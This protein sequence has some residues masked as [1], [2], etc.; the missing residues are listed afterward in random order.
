M[1]IV[2]KI[3]LCYGVLLLIALASVGFSRWSVSQAMYQLERAR[4]ANESYDHHLMLLAH[5]YR[6]FKQFG[7]TLLI[8]NLGNDNLRE[9]KALELAIKH[10]IKTIKMAIAKEI[11]MVGS[12]EIKAL[13]SIGSI[14][15]LI[16]S[17]VA[18]YRS[19]RDVHDRA[20]P[21]PSLDLLAKILERR[22][23][24]EF[25]EKINKTLALEATEM[26]AMQENT[27]SVFDFLNTVQTIFTGVLLVAAAF[28]I[29]LFVQDITKP[30]RRLI[31][32][33]TEFS[34]G[35]WAHRISLA[36]PH[37]MSKIAAILNASAKTAQYREGELEK[38]K[39][40][41]QSEIDSSAVELKATLE[42]LEIEVA[43]RKKLLADVSHELRTPLTIIQGEASVA[44]RREDTTLDEYREAL[45]RTKEAAEH[46]SIL[47]NDLLF[48]AR[49]ETGEV[50][51][52]V[53]END[54]VDV[55]RLAVESSRAL[56]QNA[57]VITYTADVTTAILEF[58]ERRMTQ[59]LIILLDN[60]CHYGGNDI[61][62]HVSQSL[63]G[64][65]IAVSDNG[66][67]IS[68]Q[69]QQQI[70]NRFFRGSNA[71][72]RFVS[73]TGLGLPV[74]QSIVVAHGGQ[75]TVDSNSDT[76][77]IFYIHLPKYTHG[78]IAL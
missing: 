67:G 78:K 57:V 32:G 49:Q 53:R 44:L 30:I 45:V 37:E 33:A 70:F 58:D 18:E 15:L 68:E 20:N 72:E 51:L 22:V 16:N 31:I 2:T 10:D 40:L 21:E 24:E 12:K 66:P 25:N 76:G 71:A 11:E 36:M 23:D 54:L 47:V 19:V 3:V 60:A 56:A 73:G 34:K 13:E 59:V 7:D 6:L 77:T 48:I 43:T 52:K 1:R 42:K 27:Q 75:L 69:D 55:T 39:T 46:T 35:N 29:Y 61:N 26:H 63:G 41:L 14:E 65:T 17:I 5:T 28:S 50:Q 4:L 64:Y 74:A 38:S 62:V 9:K 8:G